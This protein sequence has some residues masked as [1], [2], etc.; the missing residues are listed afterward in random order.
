MGRIEVD[1]V[2]LIKYHNKGLIYAMA[3]IEK[4]EG[5]MEA[6]MNLAYEFYDAEEGERLRGFPDFAIRLP[7]KLEETVADS[8]ILFNLP[9][10]TLN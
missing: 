9:N 2:L 8:E 6:A 7:K 5:Y 1:Y 10:V 4:R 3:A